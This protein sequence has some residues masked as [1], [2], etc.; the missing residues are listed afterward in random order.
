MCVSV[1]SGNHETL[2][3]CRSSNDVTAAK[4][5]VKL[6]TKPERDFDGDEISPT[7]T[8][9]KGMMTFCPSGSRLTNT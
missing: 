2:E 1:C 3:L 8:G 6:G 9:G 7:R 4:P 5:I